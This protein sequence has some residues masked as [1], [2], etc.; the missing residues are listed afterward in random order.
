ME[1]RSVRKAPTA[2]VR[3]TLSEASAGVSA[4]VRTPGDGGERKPVTGEADSGDA[5]AEGRAAG[6]RSVADGTGAATPPKAASRGTYR[7]KSLVSH[8]SGDEPMTVSR[9]PTSQIIAW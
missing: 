1:W 3:S 8:C 5:D 4:V 7:V 6:E 2:H 9:V